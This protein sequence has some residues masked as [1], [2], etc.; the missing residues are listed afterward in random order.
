[1]CTK[2]YYKDNGIYSQALSQVNYSI[3]ITVPVKIRLPNL[4]YTWFVR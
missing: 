2:N 4:G 3:K 1:M